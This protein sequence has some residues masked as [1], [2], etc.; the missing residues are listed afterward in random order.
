MSAAYLVQRQK[1]IGA[2][3]HSSSDAVLVCVD[4]SA[5]RHQTDRVT[6]LRRPRR[7]HVVNQDASIIHRSLDRNRFPGSR[8]DVFARAMVDYALCHRLHITIAK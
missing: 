3:I 1:L 4:L 6:F 5:N 8:V 2:R 7:R